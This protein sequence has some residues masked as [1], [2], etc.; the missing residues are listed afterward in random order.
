MID[1]SVLTQRGDTMA[2]NRLKLDFSITSAADRAEFV[3][4][5][6]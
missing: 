1:L 4:G 3:K 5:Y 6:L 2:T